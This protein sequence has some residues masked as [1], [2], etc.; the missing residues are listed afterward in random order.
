M[1]AAGIADANVRAMVAEF[2]TTLAKRKQTCLAAG[3]LDEVAALPICDVWTRLE[4]LSAEI[5]KQ[6]V[7]RD[8]DAKGQNRPQ[9][10]SRV[11]ELSAR[12]WLNQQR[13]AIDTDIARLALVKKLQAARTLTSTKALSQHKSISCRGF[14][15]ERVHSTLQRRTQSPQSPRPSRGVEKDKG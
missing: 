4:A 14:D 12:R 10:E 2:S 3:T 5:E 8:E 15:N 11:K 6:A 7:A 1:D 13:Q 9:L